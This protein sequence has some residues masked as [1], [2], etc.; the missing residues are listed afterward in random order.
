LP[1]GTA[2]AIALAAQTVPD[3]DPF[4]VANG[5]SCIAG[6]LTGVWEGLNQDVDG[7]VVAA[8]VADTARFGRLE[9]SR[10]GFLTSIRE[11]ESGPGLVNAGVYL[12]RRYL[13]ER[14]PSSRP[15]SFEKEV[16]PALIASQ[17]RLLVWP[18]NRPFIDIGV[19]ESLEAAG[20]FVDSHLRSAII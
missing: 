8:P 19:E 4:L 16:L 12:L 18:V 1:L 3:G 7:L 10:G 15:L 6:G 14:F 9:S 5:D 2:G 20:R 13:L 11:N 17:I